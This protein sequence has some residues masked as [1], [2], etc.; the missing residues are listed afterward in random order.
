MKMETKQ[1]VFGR[2]RKE[3]R[4]AR[5]RRGGRKTLTRIIDTVKSVTNMGRK[6]IIRAFNRLQ[7]R[8]PL[9][10][11][12]RGRP[13]YY[14]P[15]VTL[16][17]KDVWQAGDEVCGELLHPVICEYVTILDRDHMWPHGDEVTGKLL[18]MSEGTV[19]QRSGGHTGEFVAH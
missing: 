4:E 19:E 18:G 7:L 10:E 15:D 9:K 16:A 17:L 14:T 13:L 1:E 12:G 11:D 8:D 2:Y 5:G 3:Y 6:S